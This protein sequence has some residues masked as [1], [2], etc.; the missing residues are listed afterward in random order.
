VRI[1]LL[2]KGEAIEAMLAIDDPCNPVLAWKPQ[3]PKGTALK[4]FHLLKVEAPFT[5][6]EIDND[7][8]RELP[9]LV[10]KLFYNKFSL[11]GGKFRF[12]RDF[13]E[14]R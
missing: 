3:F 12:G 11:L 1:T 7:V 5:A 4:R 14:R 9:T 6:L 13:R 10:D 8:R 2:G